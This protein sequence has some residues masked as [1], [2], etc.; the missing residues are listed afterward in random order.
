MF[1]TYKLN[2]AE[3]AD[4]NFNNIIAAKRTV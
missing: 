3:D 4:K 1:S 2:H